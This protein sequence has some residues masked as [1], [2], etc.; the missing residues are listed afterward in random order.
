MLDFNLGETTDSALLL[1]CLEL[2]KGGLPVL[3]SSFEETTDPALSLL[4]LE[5][6]NGVLPMLE[7]TSDP[8]V[9]LLFCLELAKGVLPM[10]EEGTDPPSLLLFCLEFAKGVLPVLE[11]T[12]DPSDL[13]K[14]K[15][16]LEDPIVDRVSFLEDLASFLLILDP[17]MALV[18]LEEVLELNDLTEPPAIGSWPTP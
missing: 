3:D 16:V 15:G 5:L 14:A 18:P 4:C 8:P 7:E 1:F 13:E 6:A 11:E 10:L 2:A 9:L 17:W 12:T